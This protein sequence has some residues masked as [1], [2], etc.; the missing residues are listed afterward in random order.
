MENENELGEDRSNEGG[1]ERGH[2]FVE[3]GDRRLE[4]VEVVK[5]LGVMISGDGRMEEEIRSRIGKAARV[6]E[7]LNE[8]VWKW[9]ELSRRTKLR[10]YN[11][12]VVP[13]LVYGSEP[14]VLNKQRESAI[15]AVEMR[16][17]RRIAEKRMVDRVKN[18]E[19]R[20]ELKQERVLEKVKRSQ[21]RWREA[22]AEMGP[23][24]LVRRVYKAEMKGRR[25]RGRPRRKWNDN[26]KQ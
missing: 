15:Q 16:V 2:C 18:V 12:I 14:W 25:G 24:R 21:V 22:L 11:A 10:V 23:E 9:K 4:S 19:I 20:E 8:P 26:F 7:V 3:V 5:Y 1:K 17:L 6:I 13:T